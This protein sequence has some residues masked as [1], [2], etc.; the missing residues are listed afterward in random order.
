MILA[1]LSIVARL[2]LLLGLATLA[3]FLVI[4]A[5]VIG[6]G[7]MAEA[8]RLLHARGALGVEEASHLALQPGNSNLVHWPLQIRQPAV[9]LDRQRGGG[10][11]MPLPR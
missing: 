3:L 10:V 11:R 7:R 9:I 8:G 2:Y 6:S 4:G 1:R 5:S